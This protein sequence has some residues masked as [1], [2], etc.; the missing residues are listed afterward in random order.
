MLKE[1]SVF[2]Y[3]MDGFSKSRKGIE[4]R[5]TARANAPRRWL[6]KNHLRPFV[7]HALAGRGESPN[8]AVTRF[9]PLHCVPPG[10][11]L[12]QAVLMQ[13]KCL[14]GIMRAASP[15]RW[16]E[17]DQEPAE[18]ATPLERCNRQRK[19]Q[20]NAARPRLV[21]IRRSCSQGHGLL[22]AK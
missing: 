22:L 12:E 21:Q 17:S 2:A 3:N 9:T 1:S 8:S 7:C 14:R 19:W 10:R 18:R 20:G 13:G 11:A 6:G 15:R 16:S 5:L 4:F